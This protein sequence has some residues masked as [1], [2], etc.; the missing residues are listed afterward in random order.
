[1][2]RDTRDHRPPLRASELPPSRV[3]LA[4][5]EPRAV[6]C[7]DCRRWQVPQHGHIRR[8]GLDG[9][10]FDWEELRRCPQSGRAVWFDLTTAQ[11]LEA[12]RAAA[13]EAALRRSSRVHP[14][15][16]PPGPPPVFRL[17]TS[18]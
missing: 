4:R 18:R 5:G 17:G 11:W 16:R 6:V 7:P 10:E 9:R 8:H 14:G 2:S 12:L 15:A 1:M 3:M 13:R